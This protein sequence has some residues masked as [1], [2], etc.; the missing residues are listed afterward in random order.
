[1][2]LFSVHVSLII[3]SDIPIFGGILGRSS[4]SRGNSTCKIYSSLTGSHRTCCGGH[5]HS[6]VPGKPPDLLRKS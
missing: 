3:V 5:V 1:M 2:V 6:T 4:G